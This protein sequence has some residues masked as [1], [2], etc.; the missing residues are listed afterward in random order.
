MAEQISDFTA[1]TTVAAG[2]LLPIVDISDTTDAATGTTK[3]ITL[4]NVMT[5]PSGTV[6][7]AASGGGQLNLRASAD[8]AY[9]ISSDSA[10]Y[11]L[12]ASWVYG[13][14]GNN[15]QLGY[16]ID[17]AF[18]SIGFMCVKGGLTPTF[19][20]AYSVIATDT[21]STIGYSGTGDTRGVFIGTKSSTIASGSANTVVIG[22][23]SIAATASNTVYTPDLR[24]SG[25]VVCGEYTVSTLPTAAT[26]QAGSIMVSD[27]TGGYT[28]AFSDGTNWRRVQDRAIVS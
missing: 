25:V 6:V 18:E 26:Y 1:L 23:S 16:T 8:N 21:T 28:M 24:S 11:G 9:E 14:T 19:G 4:T 12:G 27:E 20:S 5:L 17:G 13:I 3:K 15:T 2:D 10:A 7:K 22:G